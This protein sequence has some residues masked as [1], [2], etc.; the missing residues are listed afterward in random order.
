MTKVHL[1]RAL[2]GLL[3]RHKEKEGRWLKEISLT[4]GQ[5][6]FKSK[7]PLKTLL[8]EDT[9]TMMRIH[10]KHLVNLEL[11]SKLLLRNISQKSV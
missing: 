10:S 4:L 6:V 2:I 7:T 9:Q 5:G 1:C 8:K 11:K 3:L